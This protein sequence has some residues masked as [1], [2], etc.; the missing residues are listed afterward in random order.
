MCFSKPITIV[1][2]AQSTQASGAYTRGCDTKVILGCEGLFRNATDLL[3]IIQISIN[4]REIS[5][6]NMLYQHRT[7]L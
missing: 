7:N 5:N 4:L 2:H 6:Y 1:A 3:L